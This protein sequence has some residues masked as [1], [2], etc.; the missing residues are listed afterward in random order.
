MGETEYRAVWVEKPDRS[1]LSHHGIKGMK[2]GVRRTDAQ[3]GHDI[4]S[5]GGGGGGLEYEEM[6]DEEKE[7][8]K[9]LAEGGLDNEEDLKKLMAGEPV[10]HVSNIMDSKGNIHT[11]H[12]IYERRGNDLIVQYGHGVN[13]D[14]PSKLEWNPEFSHKNVFAKDPD[15][16]YGKPKQSARYS[17]TVQQK[18]VERLKNDQANRQKAKTNAERY[19]SSNQ[20][21]KV[22]QL[23]ERKKN[24][25][26]LRRVAEREGKT[27]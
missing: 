17:S 12:S 25:E 23:K 13:A 26:R 11:H 18:K 21:A 5:G 22:D 9:S 1:A 16:S 8:I 4:P 3:L 7:L 15:K 2:W 19:S 27:T 14:R 6:T 24:K 20:S 10:Q